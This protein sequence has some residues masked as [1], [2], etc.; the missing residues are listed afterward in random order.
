MNFCFASACRLLP[1]LL[2]CALP[3]TRGSAQSSTN[4]GGGCF[5]MTLATDEMPDVTMAPFNFLVTAIPPGSLVNG[6][7]WSPIPT[8]GPI[9]LAQIGAPGCLLLLDGPL[10][11]AANFTPVGTADTFSSFG[12]PPVYNTPW[13]IGK[14]T[15]FQAAALVPGV[16][17]LGLAMSNAQHLVGG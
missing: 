14:E 12:T 1:A 10:L 17:H 3:L 2:A 11:F 7:F 16:N 8:P 13:W 5:G 4:V 6:L 9:D 15:W